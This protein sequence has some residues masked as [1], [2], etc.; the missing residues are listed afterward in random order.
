MNLR[1][2]LAVAERRLAAAGC[3]TPALDARVLLGHVTGRD[4]AGLVAHD[5]DPLGAQA[6][7]FEAALGRREKREPV[8]YIVGEKEFFSLPFVVGPD[9][10]VPRPETELLVE[11]GAPFLRGGR[12]SPTVVDVG[13]GSGVLAVCLARECPDARVFGLDRS[14]GALRIARA[15]AVRLLDSSEPVGLLLGDL[16]ACLRADSVDLLVSNPPYLT[17]AELAGAA[18]ELGFEPRLALEGGDADGLGAVRALL[19]DAGRVL[20]PGGR[21][22]CEIGAGQG[23]FASEVASG[24]GFRGVGVLRDLEGRARVLRAD[25]A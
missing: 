10:L 12:R 2:A 20:R 4:H 6:A 22:L 18:P 21:L 15:N 5:R 24:L 25:A 11:A 1:E 14:A 19:A 9:V 16:T 17:P 8:A 23:V 7:A 13:T 3:E